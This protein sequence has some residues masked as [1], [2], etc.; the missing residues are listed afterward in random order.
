MACSNTKKL[1]SLRAHAVILLVA[2]TLPACT[3]GLT[4][5]PGLNYEPVIILKGV[6]PVQYEKDRSSCENLT[7]QN[8]A[9]Y[10]LTNVIRFRQCLVDRGYKLM[11]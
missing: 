8:A 2:C 5:T 9:N 6:D 11:S 3:A 7:K 4:G 10:E 1:P